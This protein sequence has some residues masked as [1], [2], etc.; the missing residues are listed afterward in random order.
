MT[1]MLELYDKDVKVALQ[2]CFKRNS[3]HSWNKLESRK[4]Q[5]TNIIYKDEPNENFK[6]LTQ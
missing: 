3:E 2:K 5:E 4:P 6:T 1:E